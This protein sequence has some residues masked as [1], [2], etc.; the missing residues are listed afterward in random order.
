[1]GSVRCWVVGTVAVWAEVTVRCWVVG[2]V[3]GW[4]TVM[5]MVS[6]IYENPAIP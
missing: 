6:V 4:G 3:G 2:T 1:M 5:G